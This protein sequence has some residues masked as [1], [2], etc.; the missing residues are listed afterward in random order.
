MG[1]HT[2]GT[3]PAF[4]AGTNN[5]ITTSSA[6]PHDLKAEMKIVSKSKLIRLELQSRTTESN[7]V[8]HSLK[9]EG[10]IRRLQPYV[11]RSC[12]KHASLARLH[13]RSHCLIYPDQSHACVR[14]LKSLLHLYCGNHNAIV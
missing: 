12:D 10:P 8:K 3:A 1:T 14:A 7:E 13:W 2:D 9:G 6:K 5:D 11:T 4:T